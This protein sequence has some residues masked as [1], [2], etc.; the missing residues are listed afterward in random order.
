MGATA[1]V[2][3]A[4][5]PS[6]D[7]VAVSGEECLL[8]HHGVLYLPAW[9]ALVVSDLHLEKGSCI[10]GRGALIPPYDTAVTLQRLAVLIGRYDPALVICLGDSFHDNDGVERLAGQ[11]RDAL[12][13]AMAGRDW[14]W[15]AGNHDD[16]GVFGLPGVNAMEISLGNLIFR[17]IPA[18]GANGE[19]AGHLHPGARI[20]RRGRSV[21]R[22]CFATDG[23]RLIMPA[24]GAF[25]GALNVLDPAYDG[26]F[27]DSKLQTHVLGRD[28]LY[29]IERRHLRPG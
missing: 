4:E 16:R 11:Y 13:A 3:T 19:I 26:I 24:F 28:K 1:Q 15:V 2:G 6:A 29:R 20:V 25:T 9:R 22:R 10:A 14:I 17:H 23:N 12:L 5:T 7:T 21:R 18:N 8:D 27:E